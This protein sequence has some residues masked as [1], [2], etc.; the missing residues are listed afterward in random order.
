M[1][2]REGGEVVISSNDDA[3]GAAGIGPGL[4]MTIIRARYD[5]NQG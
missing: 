2:R 1:G 3:A 5:H 4:D